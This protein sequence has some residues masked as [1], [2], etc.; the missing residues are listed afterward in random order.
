MNNHP[1]ASCNGKRIWKQGEV[2]KPSGT[3]PVKAPNRQGEDT[4]P[5]RQHLTYFLPT[6]PRYE[7]REN[8][9]MQCIGLPW[10][11]KKRLACFPQSLRVTH[12]HQPLPAGIY[13]NEKKHNPFGPPF[14]PFSF[15][16]ME[17]LKAFLRMKTML[18][19]TRAQHRPWTPA[20]STNFPS[21]FIIALPVALNYHSS[22]NTRVIYLCYVLPGGS[23]VFLL[24]SV[25]EHCSAVEH[26]VSTKTEIT[27]QIQPGQ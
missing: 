1:Q 19:T 4:G 5:A 11:E 10:T 17:G 16:T 22:Q 18:E 13:R 2:R 27:R 25:T 26:K 3:T 14:S 9:L 23:S 21:P 7:W 6:R 20:S 24:K 15:P 12:R 8:L